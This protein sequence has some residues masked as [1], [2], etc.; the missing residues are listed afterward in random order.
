MQVVELAEQVGAAKQTSQEL[1]ERMDA[2][3]A[4]VDAAAEHFTQVSRQTSKL[5]KQVL[6]CRFTL[7]RSLHLLCLMITECVDIVRAVACSDLQTK[8]L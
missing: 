6:W 7:C 5:N 4:G 3:N 8:L 1:Q 2:A